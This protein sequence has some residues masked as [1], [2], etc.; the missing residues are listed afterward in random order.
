MQPSGRGEYLCRRLRLG[1]RADF[2]VMTDLTSSFSP[3]P[4]A[5]PRRTF[6]RVAGASAATVGLV[7]AGCTSND[8]APV[9]APTTLG[10][11]SS[12][13]T[14]SFTDAPVFNYLF[15]IKQVEFAFYDKVIAAFPADVTAAEQAHF[16]DLRDHEL[17]QRQTLASV[18]GTNALPAQAFDFTA[19]TLTTRAGVLAAAQQLEDTGAGAFLGIL[20]L[21]ASSTLFTLAAKMASVEARHA[22]LV[23]DLLT[24]GSFADDDV[25]TASGTLAGQGIA[26]TPAQVVGKD[27]QPP[28]LAPFLPSLTISTAALPTA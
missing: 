20:P 5:V 6:L 17:V 3:A 22:A 13:G 11:G 10:F 9:T 18:L 8:P 15:L 1:G 14:N 28:R 2:Y 7:L 23:R 25:V 21:I 4:G 26:L 16:R 12:T 27:A 24:P 19:V